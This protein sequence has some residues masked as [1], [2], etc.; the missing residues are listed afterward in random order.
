MALPSVLYEEARLRARYHLQVEVGR[1]SVAKTPAEISVQSEV[2]RIF[3][4]D[5]DLLCG[6]EVH[7]T[8]WVFSEGDEL[9]CGGV[10][11]MRR[12]EVEA[13]KFFEVFLDGNPPDCT[14]ARCQISSIRELSD[15]PQLR[16]P[17]EQEIHQ[18]RKE[19]GFDAPPS[20]F[21]RLLSFLRS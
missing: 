5:E 6:D 21:A 16:V 15:T 13:A 10:L 8:V 9:P 1:L 17:S 3:R 4:G 19:M 2:R 7:F 11:W 14:V 20:L 12:E 18:G